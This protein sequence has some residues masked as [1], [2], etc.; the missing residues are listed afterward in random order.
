MYVVNKYSC[1]FWFFVYVILSLFIKDKKI[2][3]RIEF[4]FYRELL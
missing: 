1:N 4:N 2:G 3:E